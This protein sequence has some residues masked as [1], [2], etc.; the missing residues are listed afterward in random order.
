MSNKDLKKEVTE[1]F[2]R[3]LNYLGNNKRAI[4]NKAGIKYR[5]LY[6]WY[7]GDAPPDPTVLSE[8]LN[9]NPMYLLFGNEPMFNAEPIKI[10]PSIPDADEF[11][12]NAEFIGDA[13]VA[14]N[15]IEFIPVPANA[16]IGYTFT[17]SPIFTVKD[18]KK[19]YKKTYKQV[20]ITGDSMLPT[21]PDGWHVTFDTAQHPRNNDLVVATANGIFVVKRLKIMDGHKFLVSD[22]PQYEKYNFNGNDDVFIHGTVIEISK[23]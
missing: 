20:R 5:T 1:R 4:A 9:V 14:E 11:V 12:A 18:V 13:E 23:Y 17:D 2:L 16:G 19:S 6:S 15:E 3:V 22:N 21:I 10:E 7:R 8:K